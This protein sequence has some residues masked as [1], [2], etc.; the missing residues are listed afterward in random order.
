MEEIYEGYFYIRYETETDKVFLGPF[1]EEEEA[2]EVLKEN[3]EL[4]K[5]NARKRIIKFGYTKVKGGEWKE[6]NFN[7]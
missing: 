2:L 6:I 5:I 1:D 4:K 7:K 3:E